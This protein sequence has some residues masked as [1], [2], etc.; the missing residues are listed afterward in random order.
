MSSILDVFADFLTTDLPFNGGSQA[1]E[2]GRLIMTGQAFLLS[3]TV[4]NTNAA[5]QYVQLHDVTAA[6]SSG[7]IPQVVFTVP[8]TS[9]LV[10]AYTMPGR[11]F[12][13]GIYVTNSSTAATLTAGSADCFYDVQYI[14]AG[15]I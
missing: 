15:V 6:P 12:H 10:V 7:A 4:L 5:A 9:N 3:V 13:R 14:P 8:A 11:R 2:A 1:L